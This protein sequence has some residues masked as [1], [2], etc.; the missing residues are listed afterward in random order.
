[1]STKPPISSLWV[2]LYERSQAAFILVFFATMLGIFNLVVDLMTL[3]ELEPDF[4]HSKKT[5]YIVATAWTIAGYIGVR[6]QS[7]S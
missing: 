6:T 4:G 3:I 5:A 2:P 1:M 7:K